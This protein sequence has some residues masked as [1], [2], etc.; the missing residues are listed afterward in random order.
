MN[1]SHI[2]ILHN[3]LLDCARPT[4]HDAIFDQV[5]KR[6]VCKVGRIFAAEPFQ[7]HMPHV[8][9]AVF[10]IYESIEAYSVRRRRK[11]TGGDYIMLSP[12][13]GVPLGHPAQWVEDLMK[14]ITPSSMT[15]LNHDYPTQKDAFPSLC[16][17]ILKNSGC[18]AS[19]ISFTSMF[20]SKTSWFA[21]KKTAL[22]LRTKLG[23]SA[24]QHGEGKV[25][26]LKRSH[27]SLSNMQSIALAQNASVIEFTDSMSLSQQAQLMSN[28]RFVFSVHGAQLTNVAWMMLSGAVIEFLPWGWGIGFYFKELY[29]SLELKSIQIILPREDSNLSKL[30]CFEKFVNMTAEQCAKE[31]KCYECTK[32][33]DYTAS[34]VTLEKI[35]KDVAQ[36]LSRMNTVNM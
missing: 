15:L 25:C 17:A 35:N 1:T 4:L 36:L 19:L 9:E 8:A 32:T 2:E 21:N 33:A 28:C 3:K 22:K 27:R 34:N 23:L 5:D 31:P 7:C 16:Q 29:D 20:I 18:T 13:F 30:P 10:G 11:I 14:L 6:A 24:E 12:V 26:I